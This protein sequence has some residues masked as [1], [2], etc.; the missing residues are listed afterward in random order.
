MN[1]GG[2]S[3]HVPQYWRL[4]CRDDAHLHFDPS[5]TILALSNPDR[6]IGDSCFGWT[7]HLVATACVQPRTLIVPQNATVGVPQGAP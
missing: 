1:G 2:D 4:P 7:L 6:I 5:D 3:R